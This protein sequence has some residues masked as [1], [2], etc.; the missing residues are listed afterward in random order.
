MKI[1]RMSKKI[2]YDNFWIIQDFVKGQSNGEIKDSIRKVADEDDGF[3]N[4]IF[5]L[6]LE[7]LMKAGK[8]V[9]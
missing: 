3:E 1:K 6:G 2:L 8:G 9:F 7:Y 5:E 4:V